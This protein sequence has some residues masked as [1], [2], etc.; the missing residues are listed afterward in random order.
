MKILMINKFLY[1]KGGAETYMLK[2]GKY[3]EGQ[4]H[5]VQYFGMDDERRTV[6]NRVQA[7]TRNMNFHGGWSLDKLT[8]AVRTIYS[9]EAREKLRL[10][11]NDFQ[12]DVCHLNNFHYQ[13]T[14]SIL[15]EIDA[16]RTVGHKKCQIIYTAHDYNLLCPNHLCRN[17]IRGE[18]CEKCFGGHF[19]NCVKGKCIHKSFAKSMTGAAEAYFWNRRGV[20]K[21]I[22]KILCCS[23]FIKTK[24]DT[25][26]LLA[27]KTIL[28]RNFVEKVPY[29]TIKKDDYVLYFGRYSEEKG[30]RTLAKV[31][32]ELPEIPFVFAGAGELGNLL[33]NVPNIKNM[34]FQTGEAL[35]E[36]IRKAKFS[37]CPSEWYENCPF[38]VL[39]SLL[40]GTPVLGADIGGIPELIEPGVTGELFESG[41][42][43]DF[44]EKLLNLW[45]G[46][47]SERYS[48]HCG[49]EKFDTVEAYYKKLMQIYES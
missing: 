5:E 42:K 35:E 13:L 28:L 48:V 49:E 9:V 8:Y 27:E 12:P 7:Y 46:K 41:N 45:N 44:K 6:G 37:V 10:V 3:L 30:I 31:C 1:P 4:G 25:Q 17:L 20:Y 32:S 11:L 2:L 18:N 15:L 23:Q 39:E 38:S 14:P 19:W 33:E 22:D 40:L 36:L 16:W 43:E 29:K 24:M 21:L 26:P 34:G 47:N